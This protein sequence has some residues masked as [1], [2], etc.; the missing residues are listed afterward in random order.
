MDLRYILERSILDFYSKQNESELNSR[1]FVAPNNNHTF[2]RNITQ[3]NQ[4]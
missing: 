2:R 3:T 1:N 4:L